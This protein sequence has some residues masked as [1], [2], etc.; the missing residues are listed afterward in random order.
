MRIR[1]DRRRAAG[2]VAGWVAVAAAASV[3]TLIVAGTADAAPPSGGTYVWVTADATTV[4][5]DAQLQPGATITGS[6]SDAGNGQPIAAE[7]IAYQG[8]QAVAR[9]DTDTG[10]YALTGLATGRYVVCAQGESNLALALRRGPSRVVSPNQ[11]R[12]GSGNGYLGRCY[13]GVA[14]NGETVPAGAE[15]LQMSAPNMLTGVDL[16][17]S[18]ASAIAGRVT[19]PGGAGLDQVV[20]TARDLATGISTETFSA[21]DGTYQLTGLAPSSHGYHVCFQF[22]LPQPV[23]YQDA[24]RTAPVVVGTNQTV[25]GVNQALAVG[26]EIAG[27]V[28][29]T[30]GGQAVEDVWV[31]AFS[32]QDAVIG[33]GLTDQHGNYVVRGLPTGS[34]ERVC[35]A[36]PTY[37]T[38]GLHYGAICWK[39]V[40]W[41]GRTLPAHTTGVA[42]RAGHFYPGINL[43]LPVT[44]SRL[45]SIAGRITAQTGGQS[46][47]HAFVA[48]YDKSGTDVSAAY[49][50]GSGR[51]TL[52]DLTAGTYRVCVTPMDATSPAAPTNGWAPRCSGGVAWDGGPLPSGAAG[53]PLAAGQRR[54]GVNLAVLDGGRITGTVRQAGSGATLPGHGVAL[55]DR[56]GAEIGDTVS[57]GGGFYSF[58]GLP[59]AAAAYLVCFYGV[60]PTPDGSTDLSQCYDD[61]PWSGRS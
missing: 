43:R 52:T 36:T 45:G 10:Q 20:V 28:T 29:S 2:W 1:V 16:S 41:N 24:C 8:G 18:P 14:W 56:S 39:A 54:T 59:P 32:P 33:H 30:P 6:V 55:F 46:L 34:S 49:T 58:G 13:N 3:G 53:V 38:V 21:A 17:L 35:A 60:G 51:F 22:E 15:Q 40:A 48:A 25:N 4:G 12:S 7:V 23:N 37:T 42:V 44:S 5:V 9:D 19:T 26:G 57:S 27:T 11:I 50:D 47:V 61:V 31:T